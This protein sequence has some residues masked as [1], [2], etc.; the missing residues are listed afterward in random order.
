MAIYHLSAKIISR[1]K[2]KSAVAAAAYRAGEKITNEYDG[3]THDYTKKGGVLHS[4]ILLPEN[5]PPEFSDRYTLWNSVEKIEKAANS[6]LAREIEISLPRELTAGQN[7]ALAREFV[8]ST[9][10]DKGMCADLCVHDKNDGNPH[11]HVLL[12]TRPFNESKTWGVKER[13]DYAVDEYGNR[14]PL[15]DPA[16]GLQKVDSRNR[17]Q[18]KRICVEVNDWNNRGNVELWRKAWGNI[19]NEYLARNYVESRV[20]H[21]SYERQ[22]IEQ[23]PTVHL[24]IAATQMEKH[25]IKTERGNINRA[26]AVINKKSRQLWNEIVG[27]KDKLKEAF[28]PAAPPTLAAMLQSILESGDLHQNYGKIRDL[29]MAAHVLGFMQK[30][31][32][33]KNSE[34]RDKVSEIHNQYNNLRENLRFYDR[35]SHTLKEHIRQGEYYQEHRNLYAIYQ[36]IKPKKQLK[37]FEENRAGLKLFEAAQRYFKEHY[38]K[39]DFSIRAWKSELEKLAIE[40]GKVYREYAPLKEQFDRAY[41]IQ[42]SAE[43]LVRDLS[44]QPLQRDKD[45]I[46]RRWDR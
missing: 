7:L 15:I 11:A 16:T 12:T 3:I 44:R 13:K 31:G 18:W 8:K 28:A 38:I 1:G 22:S 43:L 25:G 2:G 29:N 5:A 41:S 45:A 40:R 27:L 33:S 42:R 9:F 35:R 34:L 37:F 26:I 20:D 23:I 4:E 39:P 19:C 14:I 24:G 30:H 21:R 36:Q 46:S 6:Q 17:K 10:V 32:I